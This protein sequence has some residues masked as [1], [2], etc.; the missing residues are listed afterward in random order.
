VDTPYQLEKEPPEQDPNALL[1]TLICLQGI[2]TKATN[3]FRY[4]ESLFGQSFG[5]LKIVWA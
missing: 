4:T 1:I 2:R 3:K 5:V